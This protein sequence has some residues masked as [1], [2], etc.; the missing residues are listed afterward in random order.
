MTYVI[1]K[2]G[3]LIETDSEQYE[4][5]MKSEWQKIKLPDYIF[6]VGNKRYY[7]ETRFQGALDK[8]EGNYPFVLL[9]FEDQWLDEAGESFIPLDYDQ[10]FYETY[11]EWKK[12]Y[13]KQIL[14]LTKKQIDYGN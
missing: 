13:D 4:L 8:S 10:S 7:I 2:G 6:K 1:Y 3:Q 12:E 11:E 5:W 9:F 14:K